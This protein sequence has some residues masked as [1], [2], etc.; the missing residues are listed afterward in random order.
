[1]KK[2]KTVI[3]ARTLILLA[4]MLFLFAIITQSALSNIYITGVLYLLAIISFAIG[5]IVA[6]I[7]SSKDKEFQKTRDLV[8]KDERLKE[9]TIRSKAKAFDVMTYILALSTGYLYLSKIIDTNAM[10][11][12][13]VL[14]LVLLGTQLYY[15]C[16]YSKEM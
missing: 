10:I 5:A 12:L 1:M 11:V 13:G 2:T 7:A 6:F 4:V 15:F 3:I 8:Q 14:N 9:I 16:R